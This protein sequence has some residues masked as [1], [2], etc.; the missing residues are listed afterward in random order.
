MDPKK[1]LLII[2]AAIWAAL[3]AYNLWSYVRPQAK[4]TG[5]TEP[6]QLVRQDAPVLRLSLLK[7][8]RPAYRGV[9]KDIF[10][11]VRPP[12]PP[13]VAVAAPPTP[14]QKTPL[15]VFASEVK[16]IG[17]VEK[18]VKKTVF[19]SRGQDV[20]MV[21]KGDVIDGKFRVAG[22]TDTLLTLMNIAGGDEEARIDLLKR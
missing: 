1:R 11:P 21:K 8:T 2:I 17:F 19:L 5:V 20:F 10:T 7:K 18:G 4:K 13:P 22:I 16:F 12:A 9:V 3:I 14:A 15:E 6:G